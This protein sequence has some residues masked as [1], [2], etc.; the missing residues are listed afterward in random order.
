LTGG[1]PCE[2][3]L[4]ISNKRWSPCTKLSPDEKI[5]YRLNEA[6]ELVGLS[7]STF[8][9]L[10][11]LGKLPSTKVAGRRV[12]LRKHLLALLGEPSE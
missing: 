9:K 8:Y 11:K 6:A 3:W 5:A 1:D 2:Q 4:T 7:R 10:L 12:I